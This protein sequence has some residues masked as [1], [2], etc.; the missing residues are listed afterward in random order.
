MSA[1]KQPL[2]GEIAIVTGASSGIGAATARELARSGARVVLAARRVDELEA[3]AQAIRTAGGEAVAIPTDVSD[4]AQLTRLVEQTIERFGRVD[5][6]VNNAGFG[7]GKPLAETA[8]EGITQMVNVNLLSAMLL[9]RAVLPGMLAR[10]HGA[11]IS[12]ASVAG[13]IAIAPLYSG[14]KFGLRG[15][16]LSLRRELLG[17]G[18]SVSVVSPGFIRTTMNDERQGLP[19]PEVIARTIAKLVQHPRREVIRPRF[20]YIP[21][22]YHLAAC[23]EW[24]FP[25]LVDF[26]ARPR[27]PG[28]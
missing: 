22:F 28:G 12:V 25:W 5:I 19:R 9:S 10:R 27:R 21:L 16:M 7:S 2:A 26:A 13:H 3:Q 8:P 6:L 14:T 4:P 23:I 11:I 1:Q 17:S 24:L 20:F 15:F 18:V